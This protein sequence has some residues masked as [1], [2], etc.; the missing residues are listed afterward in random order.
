MIGDPAMH[1]ALAARAM[2]VW[3]LYQRPPP[4]A[5]RAIPTFSAQVHHAGRLAL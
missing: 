5:T 3:P 1:G 4:A 2:A